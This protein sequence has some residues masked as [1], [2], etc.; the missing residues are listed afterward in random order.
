M[1]PDSLPDK[2]S[3][4]ERARR[5][6][7]DA[8]PDQKGRWR[9]DDAA[10]RGPG[11]ATRLKQA[12]VLL[13]TTAVLA[14][15]WVFALA[16]AIVLVPVVAVGAWWMWRRLDAARLDVDARTRPPGAHL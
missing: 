15:V 6:V 9:L 13:I 7:F 4:T 1:T 3:R 14:M 8:R 16:L 10:L 2:R 11:W 12:V 5:D